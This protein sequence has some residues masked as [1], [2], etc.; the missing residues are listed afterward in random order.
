MT[1]VIEQCFF[2]RYFTTVSENLPIG[3]SVLKVYAND[4]DVGANAQITYS[5]NRRQSDK[6]ELFKIDPTSGLLTVNERLNYERQPVHE[7]VVV[8]KDGGEVAQETSAFITVRLTAA[9]SP[10]APLAVPK[11]SS[12]DY[13]LSKLR[14]EYLDGLEQVSEFI[15]VGQPFAQIKG[16]NGLSL[17]PGDKLSLVQGADSFQ[18]QEQG[19]EFFIATRKQ[20]DYEDKSSYELELRL[21]QGNEVHEERLTIGITDGNEHEPT[22]GENVYSTSLSESLPIG[23]SVL[24]AQATDQDQG[25]SGQISYSLRYSDKSSSSFSDWFSIDEDTGVIR[26]N[27]K[28]D[29]ELESNPQVIVVASDHGHPVKTSTATFSASISDV[30]DHSPVFSQS[31]YDVELKEDS[32]Q[33]Q[34]FLKLQASDEDCG[35]NAQIIYAL[36]EHSEHFSINQESGEICVVK[37]LDYERQKMHNLLVEAKDKGGLSSTSLVNVEIIDINDNAPEFAP[38][39]YMAKINR[40]TPLNMPILTIK[41]IDKDEDL[42]GKLSY[43]VVSG[44]E[45]NTFILGANSGVLYL[46]QKPQ[47]NSYRIRVAATDKEGQKSSNEANVIVQVQD[48]PTMFD[49]YQFDFTVPEDIS[50]YSEIGS[51]QSQPAQSSLQ[52][53]LLEQSVQGYFSL[54]SSTGAIRSEARLD[55]ETHPQVVLNIQATTSD[56]DIYFIQAIVNIQDVNDNAPEFPYPQI[57]TTIPEDFPSSGI[58]YTSL[59]TDADSGSNG[60]ISY[61]ILPGTDSSKFKIDRISGEIRLMEPVDFETQT[62]L[63]ISIEAEDQGQPALRNSMKLDILVQDVNDNAPTFDKDLYT[64]SLS[65]THIIGTPLMTIHAEDKDSFK[66]ARITYSISSNAFLDIL[67]N[68]GVLLLK[69]AIQK[70]TNPSLGLTVTATDSGLPPRKTSVPVKILVSDKN[71]FSP[72]FQRPKYTFNTLENLPRGTVVGSVIANDNDDGLNGN[73]E[74]RFRTPNSKFSIESSSGKAHHHQKAIFK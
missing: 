41:A 57:S 8:A 11:K 12:D 61:R 42:K 5:I 17:Q 22:F 47:F 27:S 59:A 73:V 40:D 19:S 13:V 68:S 20:L 53:Q 65:E 66:N 35:E 18:I 15:A 34:C 63:H 46:S 38:N 52:F 45:D 50:P 48:K 24:T 16:T 31:F 23:S 14:L 7:I 67:P 64:V 2:S 56:Q 26:T 58:F 30:N 1:K 44:N 9:D 37:S 71:D 51:I 3:S 4:A 29:C 62:S 74:Y 49:K 69:S 70:E 39:V 55:H 54:D 6:D 36:R 28:L 10:K 43:T 60:Q 25:Q 21:E 32:P 72:S 33:G